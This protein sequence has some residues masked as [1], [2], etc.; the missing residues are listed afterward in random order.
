MKI[1]GWSIKGEAGL[2]LNLNRG[3][4]FF[5]SN[6]RDRFS[7]F[8]RDKRRGYS[9]PEELRIPS[10][11]RSLDIESLISIDE[12][13]KLFD[14]AYILMKNHVKFVAYKLKGRVATWWNQL[15]NFHIQ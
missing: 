10:F 13:D 11:D 3:G 15:Q 4:R 5:N 7:N 2:L 12:I 1:K 14:M 6:R 8:I 9:N